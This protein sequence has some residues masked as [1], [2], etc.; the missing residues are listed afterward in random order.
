MEK[1]MISRMTDTPRIHK[2][3][4]TPVKK[5]MLAVAAVTLI[6]CMISI[7]QENEGSFAKGVLVRPESG[8]GSVSVNV[9]AAEDKDNG[10]DCDFD[11][12]VSPRK[13]TREEA[14]QNFA[15]AEEYLINNMAGENESFDNISGDLKLMT[16]I[17]EY[18]V[19][20]DWYSSDYELVGYDGTV[21]TGKVSDSGADVKLTAVMKCGEHEAERVFDIRVVKPKLT[22]GDKFVSEVYAAV[23]EALKNSEYED[24]VNL[25]QDINGQKIIYS[26][27]QESSV[28]IIIAGG[29]LGAFAVILSEKEN[30]RKA[31]K[32]RIK[33]MQYSYS[34]VVSKLTL[35]IGAG[36]SVRRA[37]EKIALDYE[38]KREG[39]VNYA[40]EEMLVTLRGLQSG[41]PEKTAYSEFGRRCGTK[42]YR[43]LGT[44]LEQN[45]RKGTKG[46]A[47]LLE[48]ESSEAFEQRKNLA[49]QL[50]EEAGTKL[51]LPMLLMLV[52]VMVIVMVPAVMSFQI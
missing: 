25:P 47:E 19:T 4:I 33:Q 41:V 45:V 50:G 51:L 12:I 52:I 42:E 14:F 40:Y 44:L 2:P 38:K 23:S 32:F 18:N 39:N 48:Q 22:G 1:R 29:F 3:R 36:M 13:F 6:M 16:L 27:K 11:I 10:R 20:I 35:L 21:S 5:K 17:P 46:L 24:K 30:K 9:R 15:K 37:W 43:K 7:M 49:R 26:R 34:E 31:E 8:E 28:P